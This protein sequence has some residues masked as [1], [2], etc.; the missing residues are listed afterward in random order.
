MLLCLTFINL[1]KAFDSVE[2]L[3]TVVLE[4][5][6]V[7]TI[8]PLP[9]VPVSGPSLSRALQSFCLKNEQKWSLS[10]CG[11]LRNRGGS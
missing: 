3:D 6:N 1:K 4:R 2:T 7:A 5:R 9:R 10:A 8:R 11:M